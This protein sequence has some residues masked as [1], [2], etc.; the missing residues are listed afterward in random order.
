RAALSTSTAGRLRSRRKAPRTTPGE[1]FKPQTSK[2]LLVIPPVLLDFDVQFEENLSSEEGFQCLTRLRSNLLQ[3]LSGLADHDR[4]LV[5]A[6]N[7]NACKDA[8]KFFVL[9]KP[10]NHHCSRIWHFFL[11]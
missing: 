6:I 2:R 1:L 5:I 9:F 4:F 7:E 3:F 11:G 8:L 10:I